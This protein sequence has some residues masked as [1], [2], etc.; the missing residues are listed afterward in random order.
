MPQVWFTADTHFGH[1][2]IIKYCNRPFLNTEEQELCDT[3]PRGKWR[4]SCET[5][6]RHDTALIDAINQHVATD[7]TLWILGDFCWGKFREAKQYLDRLH[8]ERV[9]LVWG[10][11]DD[12]TVGEAFHKTIEQGMIRVQGQRIWLNHYPMRSWDGRFHAS[13][14]L[15]G[16]V[17]G[18]LAHEDAARPELLTRDVGVD[19]CEYRPLSFDELGEYMRPRIEVF[20]AEKGSVHCR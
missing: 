8:C 10:N 5:V 13:W 9:N 11:H 12:R 15:Y 6:E 19:V 7:D 1:A 20:E 16:H 4:V 14:H 3:D 2:N 17:H 18:R